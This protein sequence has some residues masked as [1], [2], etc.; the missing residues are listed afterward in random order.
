MWCE[1]PTVENPVFSDDVDEEW[2]EEVVDDGL[3]PCESVG[4]QTL[5]VSPTERLNFRQQMAA[6]AGK[7]QY[8]LFASGCERPCSRS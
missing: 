3:G 7:K 6:A 2:P 5:R 8:V 1:S 4:E